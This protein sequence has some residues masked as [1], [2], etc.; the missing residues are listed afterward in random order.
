[1]GAAAITFR[2]CSKSYSDRWYCVSV[3]P[4]DLDVSCDCESG[5]CSH[6][7]AT[8]VAG[9]RAMVHPDDIE[10]ADAAMAM[11]ES[12]IVPPDNWAASWR[13]NLKWRGLS[14]KTH[15]VRDKSK[16]VVCFTGTLDRPR[17][18]LAQ[19]AREGGWEVIGAPSKY[20]D[21]LV[22]ADP[23]GPSRK[24]VIARKSNTPI[25]SADEWREI[26][27]TGELPHD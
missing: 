16:P 5:F 22:A 23:M 27:L 14:G 7:D 6:I 10:I 26:V 18:E 12:R 11:V 9:E 13:K 2:V 24:L 25:V 19:Q 8:L 4:G 1:M 3:S 21:V 17:D 20:T 15:R